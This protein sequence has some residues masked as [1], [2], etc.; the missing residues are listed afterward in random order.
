MVKSAMKSIYTSDNYSDLTNTQQLMI[1]IHARL[2]THFINLATI[3][4]Y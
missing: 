1:P 3:Q 2:T 4:Y